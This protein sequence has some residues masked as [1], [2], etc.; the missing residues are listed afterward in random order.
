MHC[1]FFE[2]WWKCN[3]YFRNCNCLMN[4]Q[5]RKTQAKKAQ[6]LFADEK[7]VVFAGLCIIGCLLCCLFC[8]KKILSKKKKKKSQASLLSETSTSSLDHLSTLSSSSAS[9]TDSHQVARNTFN[10]CKASIKSN[11]GSVGRGSKVGDM[12]TEVLNASMNSWMMSSKDESSTT[13]KRSMRSTPS[14]S[15]R[16]LMAMDKESEVVRQQRKKNNE[17]KK[18]SSSWRFWN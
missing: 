7:S 12:R 13:L 8:C 5:K 1:I 14:K 6:I 18:E 3:D 17:E 9:S 11:S 15:G 10:S 4:I 16:K 2:K